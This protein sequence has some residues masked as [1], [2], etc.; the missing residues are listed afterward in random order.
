MTIQDLT[1]CILI[2]FWTEN[3]FVSLVGSEGFHFGLVILCGRNLGMDSG[4]HSWEPTMAEAQVRD[5]SSLSKGN[6]CGGGENL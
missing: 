2:P 3:P 6:E 4:T 1:F 5:G